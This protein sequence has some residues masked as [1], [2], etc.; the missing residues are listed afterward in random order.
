MQF[1]VP[2]IEKEAKIFGPFSWKQSIYVF[3]A[4][5]ICFILYFSVS[6]PIFLLC[7]IFLISGACALAFIKIHGIPLPRVIQNF[8]I[9]QVN[10]KIF[11]WKKK[12]VVP[13]LFKKEITKIEE[14]K[15]E[16]Q[17]FIL[18]IGEGSHLAKLSSYLESQTK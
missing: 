6:F 11:L 2:Q 4:G 17:K 14:E 18:K 3:V 10:T 15:K 1:T 12:D 5:I 9:F 7:T 16:K 13:Q 8:F